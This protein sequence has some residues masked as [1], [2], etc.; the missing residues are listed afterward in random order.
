MLNIVSCWGAWNAMKIYTQ[1]HSQCSSSRGWASPEEE[2]IAEVP[3]LCLHQQFPF[4]ISSCC[5]PDSL[6][7]SQSQWIAEEA[8]IV[9]TILPGSNDM[10]IKISLPRLS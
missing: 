9:A 8:G 4:G 2:V 5:Y 1:L 3:E 10:E 6:A 7:L